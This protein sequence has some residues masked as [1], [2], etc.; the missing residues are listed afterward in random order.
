MSDPIE[1]QDQFQDRLKSILTYC[2]PFPDTLE[3]RENP[4]E[5]GSFPFNFYD[6]H[7][8]ESTRL[9]HVVSLPSITTDLARQVDD[10]LESLQKRN[11]KPLPLNRQTQSTW[12]P[13]AVRYIESM[14]M[15]TWHLANCYSTIENDLAA[16]TSQWL[17][18]PDYPR[19]TSV[20]AFTS[21][22]SGTQHSFDDPMLDFSL[23][24]DEYSLPPPDLLAQVD[25]FTKGMIRDLQ[26]KDLAT[27]VFLPAFPDV[28][29]AFKNM[30][31]AVKAPI[32]PSSACTT[33]GVPAPKLP[34][35]V[36]T[37]PIDALS[38]PWTLP[39]IFAKGRARPK[40]STSSKGIKP[41]SRPDQRFPD[42][43]KA[44]QPTPEGILYHAWRKA[45]EVDSTVIVINCGSY[46]RIGIRHRATQTL[47]LSRLI[48]VWRCEP[49]Y[50][51][52]HLGLQMAVIRDV[53]DRYKQRISLEPPKKPERKRGK[54]PTTD[55]PQPKRRSQRQLYKSLRS[56][57]VGTQGKNRK[58]QT[59]IWQAID[60]PCALV[61]LRYPPFDSCSP[62][63]CLRIGR[64]LT[65]HVLDTTSHHWKAQFESAEC[66]SIIIN[67]IFTG[68][69]A[70]LVHTGTL[71][72]FT[73]GHHNTLRHEVLIKVATHAQP[74]HRILHEFSVYKQLWTH[75]VEGVPAIYGLFEDYDGLATL[76]VME[77]AGVS[78]RD[79]Q[80]IPDSN[81]DLVIG[82]TSKEV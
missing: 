80:P 64:P 8:D 19:Y 27:W 28:E 44:K 49:S 60:R 26:Q 45:V 32:F 12:V 57:V 30:D 65:A 20:L 18:A 47:Y 29:S 2:P 22:P 17:L 13:R 14:C 58:A 23:R 53:I 42:F 70:G 68:G 67:S 39:R 48:E 10:H 69:T 59:D 3:R 37:P 75:K 55:A 77:R 1:D 36:P 35:S 41:D 72:V 78:L 71:E 81:E 62:A 24:L 54:A 31:T 33:G 66:F 61:S 21:R 25:D 40:S 74:R 43:A 63:A 51:K 56:E 76:L 46:E 52:L 7:L 79:R 11:V 50:G 9:K 73:D 6:R 5:L 38:P 82:I 16:L 4:A 15:S 34:P